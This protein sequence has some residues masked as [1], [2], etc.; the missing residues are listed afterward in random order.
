MAQPSIV[1]V[2]TV[3]G[4]LTPDISQIRKRDVTY[5]HVLTKDIVQTAG[6]AAQN[7]NRYQMEA[8]VLLA[9]PEATY[10]SDYYSK[11]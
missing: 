10:K 9:L 4:L 7:A 6:V 2:Y 1:Y 3:T 8:Q 5:A 11:H